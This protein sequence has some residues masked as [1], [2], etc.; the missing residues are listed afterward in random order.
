MK[1]I[2]VEKNVQCDASDSL[3]RFRR[4]PEAAPWQ[5]GA[6]G[7][8]AE[9]S[10]IELRTDSRRWMEPAKLLDTR[11]KRKPGGFYMGRC[12]QWGE[13]GTFRNATATLCDMLKFR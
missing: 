5:E 1:Y 2:R 7:A 13:E 9:M 4:N 3:E 11:S 12:G 6:A 10:R 8:N